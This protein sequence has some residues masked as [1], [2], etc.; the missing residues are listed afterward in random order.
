[1]MRILISSVILGI[2][3]SPAWGQAVRSPE[4]GADR[5]VTFRLA[6]PKATEVSLT[7]EFMKGS[8]SLVRDEKGVWSVTIGPV[9]PEIYYY[10]FTIDGV[11]TIDP[12]NP[13]LKTGSTPS[14]T[15]SVL[16]E[17]PSG[18]LMAA[19]PAWRDRTNWYQSSRWASC[20][21]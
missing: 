6:A 5:M 10:N 7:G 11:R 18:F 20:A 4:I 3:L 21:V 2:S 8:Q 16:S 19:G 9:E 13:N 14:T 12:G 1:M 15:S 17:A